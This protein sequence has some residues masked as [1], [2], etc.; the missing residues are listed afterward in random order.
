MTVER[1]QAELLMRRGLLSRKAAERLFSL[2]SWY[3]PARRLD[4]PA[5][6]R[7]HLQRVARMY[8]HG[9]DAGC[10]AFCRSII[11]AALKGAIPYDVCEKHLGRLPR[12]SARYAVRDRLHIAT[13]EG[14]LRKNLANI[15]QEIVSRANKVLHDDSQLT[16]KVDQTVAETVRVVC[17]LTTGRDPYTAPWLSQE[18]T[19]LEA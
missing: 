18:C 17:A 3:W 16:E 2:M 4:L 12:G 13:K 5:D 14:L 8:V 15:A 11:E 6:V 7:N 19:D 9:S 10:I 1:L